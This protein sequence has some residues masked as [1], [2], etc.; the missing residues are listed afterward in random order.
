VTEPG[1]GRSGSPILSSQIFLFCVASDLACALCGKRMGAVCPGTKQPEVKLI[2]D[3]CQVPR[4]R[5]RGAIPRFAMLLHGEG[6]N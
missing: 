6:H 3:L 4:L 1:A 5:M 2:V